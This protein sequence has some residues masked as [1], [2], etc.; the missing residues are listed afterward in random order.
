MLFFFCIC[1]QI[2]LQM[3]DSSLHQIITKLG[4]SKESMLL[5]SCRTSV[6]NMHLTLSMCN[7]NSHAWPKKKNSTNN[8]DK[9]T[10]TMHVKNIVNHCCVLTSLCWTFWVLVILCWMG[11][12]M[13]AIGQ[14]Y[15][16]DLQEESMVTG[17]GSITISWYQVKK[18]KK[19][20]QEPITSSLEG[21]WPVR[22]SKLQLTVTIQQSWAW[23]LSE[24]GTFINGLCLFSLC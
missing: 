16:V 21:V 8:R 10:K 24:L 23:N 22:L 1:I 3:H 9:Q 18:N 5:C 12:T 2:N 11:D 19:K 15:G 20:N 17:W 7:S 6:F 13:T 14:L 4:F